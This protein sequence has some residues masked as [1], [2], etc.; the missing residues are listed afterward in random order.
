MLTQAVP[1]IIQ[2][3]GASLPD[4]TVKSLTQAIGNCVQPLTHRGSLNIQPSILGNRRGVYTGQNW[5]SS[6]YAS[7]LPPAGSQAFADIPGYNAGDWNSVNY[8]GSQ[9]YFPTD[10]YF[11]NS[12]FY[13]GD[14]TNIGG[15]T[16][17]QN[18]NTQ[19]LTVNNLTITG[20]TNQPGR[21][22][23]DG[24]AGDAGPPGDPGS[25]EPISP[26]GGGGQGQSG[27]PS[28]TVRFVTGLREGGSRMRVIKIKTTSGSAEVVT[29]AT[30]NAETC[31]IQLAT[32]TINYISGVS[33]EVAGAVASSVAIREVFPPNPQFTSKTFLKPN[34]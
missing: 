22:G 2:A 31:S 25:V 18:I 21:D 7:I 16:N 32:T 8:E 6:K 19:N 1:S 29:G 34:R 23:K 11:N 33:L 24:A 4:Q 3:L 13:G 5:S 14:T 15:D 12:N 10:N 9:F 17:F 26:P 20:G 27:Y 28:E 30:F